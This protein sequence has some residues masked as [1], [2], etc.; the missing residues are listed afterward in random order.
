M[1]KNSVTGIRII[2]LKP[3][4]DAAPDPQHKEIEVNFVRK[5]ISNFFPKP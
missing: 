2:V 5:A 3:K 4:N 1:T